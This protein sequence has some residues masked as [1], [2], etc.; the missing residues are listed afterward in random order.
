MQWDKDDCAWM[1]LVKFDLLGLGMLSAIQYTFDLVR[2]H[3]GEE[4]TLATIPREEPGVYDQLCRAD[5]IGVFQVESRAQMGLLPRLQPRRF[6]DLVVEIALVRPGPIQ[7]GAVHPFVRRKLGQEPVTYLHP[8]LREPLERTLGVPIFQEQL[9]QVAMAVG[10]CTGDDADLLRRAMGSKRGIERIDSLRA[11]LYAGM[12]PNG[13]VGADADSIYAKIQAFAG[14]GFAESHALSFGLLVY[15]SAWLRLHYPAA[16][17][18]S[19]LRAQPM[20]FY[21]PQSLIS[22]ARRHGVEVLRPDIQRSLA[23]AT[24][25]PLPVLRPRRAQ[26]RARSLRGPGAAAT[27]T[28]SCLDFEQP[29]VGLF[30]ASVPFVQ[31]DHTRDGAF[32]VRLGLDEVS[33]IGTPLAEKIVAERDRGGPFA[34]MNDLVRRTGLETKQLEVLAAAGA[35]DC[36]GLTPPRGDVER[37]QRRAG[38]PGVPR[39]HRGRGAAA[40]VHDAVTGRGA[41]VRPV[42]D[43]GVDRQPPR[44]APAAGAGEPRHPVGGRPAHRGAGPAHRGRRGRDPPAAAGDGERHHLHEPRG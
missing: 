23:A 11:K 6:Y 43:R 30:D 26:R 35:F 27:G 4:W 29:P 25:E 7:G 13:I 24:L 21:S 34:D 32:A 8:K 17:L 42:G 39:G 38:S 9:M 18:A 28:P 37:G 19:L 44:A 33:G 2:D 1:G 12:K 40:A 16:F 5:S 15:A 14:F 3:L 41:H 31:A 36:F 10:G 20:G 22:D